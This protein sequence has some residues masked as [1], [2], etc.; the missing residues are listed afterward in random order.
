MFATRALHLVTRAALKVSSPLRAK[1]WIDSLGLLLPSLSVSDA[2]RMAR[3]LEPSGSCLTRALTIAARLRG[4]Q[5]VIGANASGGDGARF[6]AHAWVEHD[7]KAIGTDA[8][9]YLIVR[10]SPRL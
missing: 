2:S 7:G 8:T 3:E 6:G 9:P 1:K 10:L 4:S 5:V